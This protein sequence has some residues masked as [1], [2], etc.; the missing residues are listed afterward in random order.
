MDYADTYVVDL[1]ERLD[2]PRFCALVLGAAPRWLERLLAA[3]DV[4]AG[5]LGF[6]TQERNYGG[7]V[8]LE[9]GR[10]FGPLLVRSVSPQRVVCGDADRHLI[11]RATFTTDET[12]PCGRLTT[13]VQFRDAV[14][15]WYFAAIKPFHRRIIPVLLSAPFPSRARAVPS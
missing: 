13:E 14:G 5:R 1:A 12:G 2:A 15:R 9:V 11:M 4:V 7:P 8:E 6:A 10:K 3:R